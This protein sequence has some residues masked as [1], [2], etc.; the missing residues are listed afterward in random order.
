MDAR[1][2]AAGRQRILNDHLRG[3]RMPYASLDMDF[4]P[5][6]GDIEL[7]AI[8]PNLIMQAMK[9]SSENEGL[10]VLSLNQAHFEATVSSCCLETTTPLDFRFLE[11]IVQ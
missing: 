8:S 2:S 11:A 10:Q 5:A 7:F 1:Q 9:A 3:V 4:P 6:L